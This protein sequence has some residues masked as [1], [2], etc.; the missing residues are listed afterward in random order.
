MNHSLPIDFI[1]KLN[2]LFPE[3]SK[4]E[5]LCLYY[6]S[7]GLKNSELAKFLNVSVTTTKTHNINVMKKLDVHKTSELRVL[8]HNRL[9]VR[10]MNH[11]I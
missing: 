8:F 11:I 3:L 9:A 7:V 6:L 10:L 5:V 4:K 2:L 1:E